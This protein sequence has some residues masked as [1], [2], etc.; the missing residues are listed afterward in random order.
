MP[1]PRLVKRDG[2]V[3]LLGSGTD[4]LALESID[5]TPLVQAAAAPSVSPLV[6]AGKID[7]T[8]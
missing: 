7:L 6:I 4:A 3:F 2:K 1:K 5:V 8:A